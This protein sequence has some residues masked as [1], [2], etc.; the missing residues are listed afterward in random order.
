V[1]SKDQK[2]PF[3]AAD[4]FVLV[5]FF[6]AQ[7][8]VV[9]MKC[10]HHRIIS[11]QRGAARQHSSYISRSGRFGEREDLI[12]SGFGNLPDWAGGDPARLW[13]GS[14]RYER[15]NASAYREHV[16]ALPNMMSQVQLSVVGEELAKAHAGNKPYQF[17]VHAS[18]G[19]ISAE[20]NPHVHVMVCDRM[21]DGIARAVEEFFRR[22]NSKQ[23]ERGGARKDSG[24][25]TSMEL[26]DQV[27]ATR[28]LSADVI[29]ECSAVNGLNIRVDHRSFKSRGI[30]RAPEVRQ[31]P[32]R[33]RDMTLDDKKRFASRRSASNN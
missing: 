28:K 20:E 2:R 22:Y 18:A 23:P 8:R 32:A 33:V 30:D 1:P 12:H 6:H 10:I 9:N 27:I 19:Q 26:R 14:D 4:K 11:G 25:R 3:K 21:P 13:S 7:D 17:A 29:N 31:G 5:G 24:G 15:T 16:I